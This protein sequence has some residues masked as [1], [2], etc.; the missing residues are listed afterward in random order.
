MNKQALHRLID[1]LDR[2]GFHVH[3]TGMREE[4]IRKTTEASAGTILSQ[5]S[6]VVS[7]WQSQVAAA[8][9]TDAQSGTVSAP[10]TEPAPTP[11]GDAGS[12]EP[13]NDTPAPTDTPAEAPAD[14]TPQPA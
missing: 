6:N 3:A 10:P 2:N 12:D 1:V 5:A 7:N 13:V 8:S 11:T 4:S 9:Q 14:P